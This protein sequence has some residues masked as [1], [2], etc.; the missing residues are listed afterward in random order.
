[1]DG[2]RGVGGRGDAQSAVSAV[3]IGCVGV[4]MAYFGYALGPVSLNILEIVGPAIFWIALVYFLFRFPFHRAAAKFSRSVQTSLG[5]GVFV[6]YIAIHL[7][8]YGFLLDA[9]L[10]SFYGLSEFATTAGFFLTTNVYLP[11]SFVSTVFDI[12]YNPVVV[13]SAPPVFSAALSFYSVAV[14]FVIAVLIV[15]N[16]GQTREL[17][18]LRTIAGRTKNFVVLPAMGIVLGASCCIS[19]AGIITLAAPATSFLT[20]PWIYYVTYFLFPCVAVAVL[21]LNLRS[22]ERISADVAPH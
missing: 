20:S 3:V 15:A 4:A 9:V 17:G 14:A 13:V 5:A 10:A 1:M 21:Y 19:V 11:S 22:V 7:L 2:A 18:R 16:I 12:A 8:L 6:I